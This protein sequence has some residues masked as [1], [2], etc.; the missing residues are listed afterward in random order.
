MPIAGEKFRKQ[1]CLS[2]V[3]LVIQHVVK[4]RPE[5]TACTQHYAIHSIM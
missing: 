4:H 3:P 1:R 2:D 5:L